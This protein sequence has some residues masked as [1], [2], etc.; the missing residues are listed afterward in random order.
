MDTD[1]HYYGTGAAAVNAGFEP[2]E[3]AWIANAAEFVDWFNSDYWSYWSL[4]VEG[5]SETYTN[6]PQLSCQSIDWKMIAD[7]DSDIWNAFHFP[8]GNSA[9]RPVRGTEWITQFQAAHL[10]RATGLGP[11]DAKKLCRPYSP[12]ALDMI[13]DTVGKCTELRKLRGN[14]EALAKLVDDWLDGRTRIS[15]K[16]P[17]RLALTLLGIR[18]HILADTWAHQDFTGGASAAIN[19][20]G[21]L[22]YIYA[23]GD[24]APL[25]STSW[26]GTLWVLGKDTDCAAAPNVPGDAACRGHGQ[27]GHFPDY[28]W[29]TFIYPA[30]WLPE[31]GYLLRNNPSQYVPAWRWLSFVMAMANG[32]SFSS[33]DACAIPTEIEATIRTPHELDNTRLFAVPESESVWQQTQLCQTFID[34]WRWNDDAGAFDDEARTKLGVKGGALPTTRFQ[35]LTVVA[36]SVLHYMELASALHYQWCVAWANKN[37]SYGWTPVKRT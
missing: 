7:Y 25:Q 33:F 20:A 11:S 19:G 16:D 23:G 35:S 24:N 27:V 28:S 37:Q 15:V 31:G 22:N 1:F 13:N 30:A 14:S 17:W 3:A 2:E 5:K 9:H 8:P 18:M 26:T 29:L 32:R 36:E 12:F 6:Y 21:T 34:Q 10:V 4:F